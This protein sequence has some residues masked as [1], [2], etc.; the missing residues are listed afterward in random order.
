MADKIERE[1]EPGNRQEPFQTCPNYQ[2]CSCNSCPLDPQIE[3]RDHAPGDNDKCTAMRSTREKISAAFPGILPRGGLTDR[4]YKRK[5]R[6]DARTPAE[7]EE[8]RE[9]MLA[10]RPGSGVKVP[11]RYLEREKCPDFPA[12]RTPVAKKVSEASREQVT[13]R[14]KEVVNAENSRD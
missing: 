14:R 1:Q 8:A 5:I 3:D 10:I 13:R 4:E 11:T 6:R 12:M 9:R 7:I 2:D